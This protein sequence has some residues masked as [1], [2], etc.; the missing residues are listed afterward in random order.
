MDVDEPIE[1]CEMPRCLGQTSDWY[2]LAYWPRSRD[3]ET[4]L[5]LALHRTS[6]ECYVDWAVIERAAVDDTNQARH[7]AQALL[8]I[9]DHAWV[10]RSIP[11]ARLADRRGGGSP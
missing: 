4:R 5:M 10:G 3:L 1:C 8:A 11:A 9:R 2:T 7:L 6:G